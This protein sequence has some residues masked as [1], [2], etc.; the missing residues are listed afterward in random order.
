VLL[1]LTGNYQSPSD[2]VRDGL[3][4][5]YYQV[6]GGN[7]PSITLY[8]SGTTAASALAA[9]QK[10]VSDGASMVIGPLTKDSVAGLASQSSLPV[11]VL[12]LNYLDNNRGGPGGFYQ[13]GLLPEGEAAQVAERAVAEGRN[14]AVALVSNDDFGARMFNAFQARFSELGGN[15]LGMHTYAPKASDYAPVLTQLFGLDASQEREQRLASTI[16]MH[17]EYDPRRR[18]DIQFVFL[19]AGADDA[20]T[21][22]PQI[23]Y[24]H[25]EDLPVYTTSKV[26][27]LDDNVDN[28]TLNGVVFDDMPWTLEES[29][30]V[31]DMRNA[32]HKFWP[33]NFANNSRLYA[34]GFDAYRLV[35][36][37]YNTHGIAQAVQGVTGFLSMDPNGRVHRRLDWASF[38]DGSADLLAPVDLPAQAPVTAVQPAPKP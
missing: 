3:M 32:L 34:L 13:F 24:N 28:T 6:G 7:P 10:A 33:N 20:R 2:A 27:T 23:G 30:S 35:P 25:G 5:A 16:S 38:E 37:L 19:A 26:Y 1:P 21:L 14:H 12:A 29:G 31:A 22:Q 9:Y 8:D 18:Q 11:P 15:L 17:M 4:A 36:L